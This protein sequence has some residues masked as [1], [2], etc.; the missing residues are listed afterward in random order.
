MKN[1]IVPR[2]SKGLPVLIA[3]VGVNYY[4]I[5]RKMGIPVFEAAKLMIKEARDA[6]I[7]AIKFQSYKAST[8]VAKDSP[9]YWD[10]KE[11]PITSQYKLFQQFDHF[12]K[13][14]YTRLSRYAEELGIEFFSTPFDVEAADYLDDLMNVYKISSSDL[15]NLPFIAYQAK[16]GKPIL[17]SVGASDAEEIDRSVAE[18][19]KYNS[20]PLVLLHCVLEYPTPPEEV[21]LNKICSLK[22]RY[23]DCIIGYSDHSKPHPSAEIQKF[24]YLLGAVVI[25][26]H[27]TL[28]KTLSGN[29]HFHA[30][31]PEDAQKILAGFDYVDMIRGNGELRCLDGERVPRRNAR[32]SLVTVRPVKPGEIFTEDM[33]I[34]KRPGIGIAPAD[35]GKLLGKKSACAID[36]DITMTW[37]MVE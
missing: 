8:L 27:F 34:A 22:Q 16:K 4:D 20:C 37:D 36:E 12:G 9:S 18:I 13:E 19:R 28:D 11:N 29:D 32:R 35:I 31:D 3:D 33:F 5:A 25:E 26:K 17:L 15:N 23:P 1:T 6:G 7:H 30:M 2:M 14:E 24:A 10:L 21:N